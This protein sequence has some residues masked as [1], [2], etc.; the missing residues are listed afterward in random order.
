M[1]SVE[2]GGAAAGGEEGRPML[3]AS[4]GMSYVESVLR[5]ED[6]R[7]GRESFAVAASVPM[8]DRMNLPYIPEGG[9][10]I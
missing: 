10:S 2:I 4:S 5:C 8:P 7:P 6:G 3:P 1:H 9:G